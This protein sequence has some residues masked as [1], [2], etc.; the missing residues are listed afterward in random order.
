MSARQHDA[1][2][3]DPDVHSDLDPAAGFVPGR[4]DAGSAGLQAMIGRHDDAV[5]ADGGAGPYANGAACCPEVH[6]GRYDHA[7]AQCQPTLKAAVLRP[8]EGD[9]LRIGA[10]ADALAEFD[11]FEIAKAV[12]PDGG[13]IAHERRVAQTDTEPQEPSRR[14][15]AEVVRER[16]CKSA[17][18]HSDVS[19][20]V[21]RLRWKSYAPLTPVIL[22]NGPISKKIAR[23]ATTPEMRL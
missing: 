2:G 10:Y 8:A 6:A 14:L 3:P 12:I 23:K 4:V 15:Q 22:K 16:P 19:N 21:G 9:D 5:L 11:D 1:T 20:S 18:G 7:V 17:E 13:R